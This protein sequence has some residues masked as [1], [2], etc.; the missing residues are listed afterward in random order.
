MCIHL[1]NYKESDLLNILL[2]GQPQAAETETV[3]MAF[4]QNSQDGFSPTLSL[5]FEQLF[6]NDNAIILPK[7]MYNP[8]E[9]K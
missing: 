1:F 4:R 8:K 9:P 3:H 6:L 5:E 2:K 7:N